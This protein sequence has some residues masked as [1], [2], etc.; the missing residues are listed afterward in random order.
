[1]V[2]LKKKQ[3]KVFVALSGGVDSSVAAALLKNRGYDVFGVFMKN[4]SEEDS[5]CCSVKRDILDACRVA[6]KLN[7][8]F[9][10][11]DFEKDYRR[12][13]LRYIIEGY[14]K[15]FTP[16]PDVL[17]NKKIKF[18]LFLKKA[19]EMGANYIATGHYVR[20]LVGNKKSPIKKYKIYQAKDKNKDQSYF[21]WT[22]NQEQLKYCLF[23]L[24]NYLKKQ[25]RALAKKFNL[26]TAEKKDS[27]GLCFVGNVKMRDFLKKWLPEKQG[28]ILNTKG[29]IIG[30]HYGAW[31]YTIGQRQ[32]LNISCKERGPYFV[33]DKDIKKNIL[34]VAKE[35]EKEL[36]KDNIKVSDINWITGK[37]PKMPLR[38]F[39]KIRYRQP[40]QQAIINEFNDGDSNL[41]VDFNSAQK[42]VAAGQSAVFYRRNGEMLGGGIIV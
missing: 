9:Q 3:N 40:F 33:V 13:I 35:G 20:L 18:G 24:G 34:I 1:M 42:G 17:C 30:K 23:P 26:P 32:G 10:I 16:N 19:L 36:F 41:V 21:L 6:Q 14:K 37:M 25:V 11:F 29:E 22:L 15:G 7:I 27:Q 2:P 12:E 28:N 8:P 4:W 39:V 31:F 38:C 5:S